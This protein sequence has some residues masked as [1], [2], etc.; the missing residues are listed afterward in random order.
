MILYALDA[1]RRVSGMTPPGS[2]WRQALASTESLM[3]AAILLLAPGLLAGCAT[4]PG[5]HGIEG[6]VALGQVAYVGGPRVRPDR[7]IEDSR[8]P[9]GTQCVWAGRVMVRATV[10][11]GN[12]SK[13]MDLTLGTPVHVADGL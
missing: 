3:K 11:G 2:S 6:P 10:I 9:A 4:T 1:V 8:C 12:W 5:S 7:L 13:Q